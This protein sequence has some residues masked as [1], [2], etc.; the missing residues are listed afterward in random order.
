MKSAALLV[1]LVAV[2]T[3]AAAVEAAERSGNA[4]CMAE[5]YF[6]CSQIKI[7]S[8]EECKKECVFACAKNGGGRNSR[9]DYDT[10]FFP[11]WI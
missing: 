10:E 9:K 4:H 11:S 8:D 1:A 5:C 7:F 3:A 2:A 6:D